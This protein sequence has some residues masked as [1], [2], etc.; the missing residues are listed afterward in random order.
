MEAGPFPRFN[1]VLTDERVGPDAFRGVLPLPG[2]RPATPMMATRPETRR[3]AISRS[4]NLPMSPSG[5]L[6]YSRSHAFV[7]RL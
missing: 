5:Q 7:G 4:H 3:A 1:G 2:S 6:P